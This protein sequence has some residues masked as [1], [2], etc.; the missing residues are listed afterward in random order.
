MRQRT[1]IVKLEKMFARYTFAARNTR[2]T[3]NRF[4]RTVFLSLLFGLGAA[5]LTPSLV[6]A[7][8]KSGTQAG[9][10]VTR[11]LDESPKPFTTGKTAAVNRVETYRNEADEVLF[12]IAFL[13]PTG[14]VIVSPDDLIEPIIGYFPNAETFSASPDNPLGALLQRDMPGRLE[15]VRGNSGNLQQGK[16]S[17]SSL[18][19]RQRNARGKW[20]KLLADAAPENIKTTGLPDS[21]IED[22]RVSPLISSKWSQSTEGG[23]YCYNYYTPEH[24]VS[25]CVATAMAQLMRFHQYPTNGVGTASYPIEVDGAGTTASLRG[26]D[27]LGGPYNWSDMVLDPDSST[28][29]TERQAIGALTYDAGVAVSMSYTA[30]SSGASI[31][32]AANELVDTFQ[33]ANA[34]Y[35]ANY[36]SGWQNL[37]D[38]QIG[39]MINTN[40]DAG[41]PVILGISGSSGGHAILADGFGTNSGTEYH[42]LNMGW[43]GYDDGWYN[44]P[45]LTTSSYNFSAVDEVVYNIYT[46]GSGEVISGRI[47]DESGAPL[48]GVTVTADGDG[49]S[50]STA[51]NSRGV[52]AFTQVPSKCFLYGYS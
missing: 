14:L 4:H 30:G 12:Y 5:S 15:K 9:R 48:E 29:E 51:T 16:I 19:G 52:F 42:H 24:Y 7:A 38:E 35:G 44:M 10:V 25:G 31:S 6:D 33:Y 17:F 49:N 8:P 13:E 37:T 2:L 3:Q 22:I 40:I 45:N 34:V 43:A 32:D 20:E 50:Y 47:L 27:G 26:G 23:N 41:Y 46:S 21:S 18:P 11:W 1:R 36:S 39:K 28:T